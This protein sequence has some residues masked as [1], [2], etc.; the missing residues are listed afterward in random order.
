[1]WFFEMKYGKGCSVGG[2]FYTREEMFRWF[3][4]MLKYYTFGDEFYDLHI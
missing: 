2:H 1:M 3:D 4:N